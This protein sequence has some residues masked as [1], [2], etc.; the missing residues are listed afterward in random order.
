VPR[1][2]GAI[3]LESGRRY[4]WG[5]RGDSYYI[6]DKRHPGDALEHAWETNARRE[7]QWLEQEAARRRRRRWRRLAVAVGLSTLV[8]VAAAA[9]ALDVRGGGAE[10][11]AAEPP[12]GPEVGRSVN[13]GG[14]YGFRA[15]IGWDVLSAAS[16]ALV[17]NPNRSVTISIQVAPEGA[18]GAASSAFVRDLTAAWTDARIE[19]PQPR[20]VGDLAGLSVRGT[21]I[22]ETGESI[23]FFTIVVDSGARNHA[24][25][26]SMPGSS[27]A[28]LFM[29]AVDLVLSSFEPLDAL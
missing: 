2:N 17:T 14:G 21:A 15:P 20:P 1:R 18:V 22:D 25:S 12:V 23:R 13:V 3:V 27:D 6:W 28:T 11:S 5:R 10:P 26:V 24:I 29:P 4:S 19:S 7:F 8:V 9:A 16:T